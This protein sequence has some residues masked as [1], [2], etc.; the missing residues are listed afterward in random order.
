MDITVSHEQGRVPVTVFRIKGDLN[1]ATSEQLRTEAR[2]AFESGARNLLLDLSDVPYMSSAGIRTLNDIFSLLRVKDA[3]NESDEALRKGLSDGT[4]K[5]PHLKLL[6][7][8]RNVLE[9]LNMAGVDMFLEIHRN[10]KEA[11]A[12]F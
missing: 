7:P 4:F 8:N 2:Q 1:M 5:S 10:L 11:V 6:N 9:V 12:S 3:P